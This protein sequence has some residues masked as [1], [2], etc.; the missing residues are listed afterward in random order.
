[1]EQTTNTIGFF[2]L[3]NAGD[4]AVVRILYSSTEQITKVT[5]HR[6]ANATKTKLVKCLGTEG[7]GCPCCQANIPAETRLVI[8]LWDYTDNSEK[9]WERT[10]N[11]KFLQ[12]LSE[13]EQAWGNL[14]DI[15]VKITRD[16]VEFPTYSVTV[17]PANAYPMPTNVELNKD[18]SFRLGMYRS[19]DEL[20]QAL[21]TGVVP[22]HVKKQP[23]Q[24][25][26]Q[27]YRAPQAQ[28]TYQRPVQTPPTQS[29]TTYNAQTANAGVNYHPKQEPIV[30]VPHAA[31]ATAFQ[32]PVNVQPTP[33]ADIYA[34]DLPF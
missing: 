6:I 18:C 5:A 9:I 32:Q 23:T 22:P 27:P 21:A 25:S 12:S 17:M 14:C 10:A 7:A 30:S 4:N 2:N 16:S 19:A 15:P 34:E 28:Q 24:T 13:I 3:K 1:M 11:A 8:H 33:N 29:Q 26:N 20:K 31:P